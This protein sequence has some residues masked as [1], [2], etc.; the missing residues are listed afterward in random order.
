VENWRIREGR[1]TSAIGNRYQKSGDDMTDDT[2][3][4][5]VICKA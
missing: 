5:T 2:I 3:V 1:G 4:V